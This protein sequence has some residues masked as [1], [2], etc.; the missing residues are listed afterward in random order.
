MAALALMTVACSNDD[1]DIQTPAEQPAKA[2]GIPFTATISMGES[3]ST[4]ALAEDNV[5]NKIV[6]TW[7]TG[8]KVAL[9]YDAGG[10]PAITNA[11]VTKQTDGTATISATLA[12]GATNGSAVTIIYPSDAADGTT[13]NVK[14]NLL[15]AQN[16]T[17]TGTGGT[18]IAEK[19]DVR[20]GTG[21]LSINA[22]G[23][24]VNNGTAGTPVALAAQNAI[25]KFTI[26]DL[27][28]ADK[29][30]SK[31]FVSDDEGN[32]IT[33]V[34][35]GSATDELYVALPVMTAGT[36][37]FNA[38]I[39]EKPYIAK[40]TTAADTEV[41]K[42][43]QTTVKMATIGDVIL[44]NGSF[45]VKGTDTEQAVIANIGYLPGYFDRFIAIAL[46]DNRRNLRCKW[47]NVAEYVNEYATAHAITICGTTYNTN[48]IGNNCYDKTNSSYETTTAPTALVKGWRLPSVTDWNYVFY[49]ISSITSSSGTR[50][51]TSLPMSVPVDFPHGTSEPSAYRTAINTACGN[52]ALQPN[53]YW[54]SSEQQDNSNSKAVYGFNEDNSKKGFHYLNKG[55]SFSL[56]YVRA[57]FA[58]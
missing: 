8:E 13:G 58:Y 27:S 32:V 19:Y 2:V 16:G 30:A 21:K 25:F 4:R 1:S 43:Y 42:Y 18:S 26:Q 44:S 52:D 39:G 51:R 47:N 23:A 6:A 14:A 24:T 12:S 5:N 54:S 53:E 57:V 40:A 7:E 28:A 33:I 10:T 36:Y 50:T 55:N 46:T 38:T 20:K 35:P 34:T 49:G 15:A 31:F 22:G 9:I 37:W 45:A 56:A 48:A 3:A 29:D 11:T 41:G 17:L